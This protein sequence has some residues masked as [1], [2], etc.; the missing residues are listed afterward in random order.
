MAMQNCIGHR[1]VFGE[2]EPLYKRALAIR[3]K[4]LRPDHPDMAQTLNN[5][6]ELYC[7]QGEYQERNPSTSVHWR[8]GKKCSAPSI[9]AWQRAF[10]TWD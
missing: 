3:E 4:S 7:V 1:I 8:Y 5:L 9:P 10:T 6:A 2:A